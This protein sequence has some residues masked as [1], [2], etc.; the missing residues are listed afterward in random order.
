MDRHLVDALVGGAE[1]ETLSG[2]GGYYRALAEALPHMLWL[3][4]S[5]GLTEYVNQR[6]LDFTGLSIPEMTGLSWL[7]SI[8]PDDREQTA[9]TQ[10][11]ARARCLPYE[12]EHRVRR[13]DGVYVWHVV[14]GA[15]V[16]DDDGQ[17]V[18]WIGTSTN[19]ETRK[20]TEEALTD[21]STRLEMLFAHAPI[22]I[23]FVD[24]ELR[25]VAVNEA[26]AALNGV[27]VREHIGRTPDEVIPAISET[28]NGLLRRVL[29]TGEPV[30]DV[31]FSGETAAHPGRKHTWLSNYYPVPGP[32]GQPHGVGVV[33]L[34]ITIRRHMESQFLQTQKLELLG[35]LSSAIAHDFNNLLTAI[36]GFG[37]LALRHYGLG[38][39]PTTELEE[40]LAASERSAMLVRQLLTFTTAERE[41]VGAVDV[42]QQLLA[43]RRLLQVLAGHSVPLTLELAGDLPPASGNPGAFE[44]IVMNLT[45]NARDAMPDGGPLV[46]STGVGAVVGESAAKRGL[47]PGGYVT[48]TVADTGIGMDAATRAQA[49][50]PFFTTKERSEGSGLGL[51]TVHGLVLRFGGQLE[52]ESTPGAGTRVSVLLPVAPV[53]AESEDTRITS[54]IATGNETILVAEDV[55]AVRRFLVE[56]LTEAGY[57]V[58][59]AESGEEALELAPTEHIDLLLSDV[60][61]P[62]ISGAELAARLTA[63]Y[64]DLK[65]LLMSGYANE[66]LGDLEFV[67]K[68]F[69]AFHLTHRIRSLIEG[70]SA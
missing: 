70:T 15:P 11:D 32:E 7:E 37:H 34:D 6:A 57:R 63:A 60:V 38:L 24:A 23:G 40:V 2:A 49:L 45:T 18:K 39:D 26:L 69:D 22:G 42:N 14:R 28:A 19:I 50:Q 67:L 64:P 9:R 33:I 46:I 20:Q 12:V 61:M 52:L 25:Y 4:S 35:R 1:P 5:D 31:E 54:E 55:T 21:A 44:Q 51:S 65:V 16:L 29:D 3:T 41:E 47:A 27:P 36:S 68:P 13:H 43:R 10:D 56:M 59:A 62:G 8:H 30:L 66:D 48:V 58:L 17:V 53:A